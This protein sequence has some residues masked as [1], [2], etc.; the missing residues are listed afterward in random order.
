[1]EFDG[2]VSG[3]HEVVIGEGDIA[4]GAAADDDGG[5]RGD[6]SDIARGG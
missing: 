1:M 2:E 4:A 5:A 3:G 6:G